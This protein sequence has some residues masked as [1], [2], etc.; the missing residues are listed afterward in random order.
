VGPVGY[1]GTDANRNLRLGGERAQRRRRR[2]SCA[3]NGSCEMNRSWGTV[4]QC[5]HR[6]NDGRKRH[7]NTDGTRPGNDRGVPRQGT[8]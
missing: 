8:Q 3:G 2:F 6:N 7:D 4:P 5:I 1:T